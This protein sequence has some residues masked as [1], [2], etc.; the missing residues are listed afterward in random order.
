M[1]PMHTR[2]RGFIA[3]I[4]AI[5][6]SVILLGL[7]VAVGS[8]TFFARF[9]ALNRE[10]KRISLGLAES[11]VHAALAKIS[12]DYDYTI[13]GDPDYDSGRGGVVVDLD[14]VYDRDV[15]CLITG[16]LSAPAEVGGKKVFSIRTKAQYA[17]AFSSLEVS[18]TAQDPEEAPIVPPPNC[19]LQ[20]SPTSIPLGQSA[21]L[22]WSTTANADSLS[23]DHGVGGVAVSGP[24]WKSVTPAGVGT[25][26]Y[27]ATVSNEGGSNTCD[28]T[29]TVVAPP[30]A[31]SC[32][33][34][35]M[36]LDRS[37]S[38]FGYPDYPSGYTQWVP[39]E[40]AAAKTLIDLYD[41]VSS[42]PLVGW[43][44]IGDLG[45]G[46]G[47][48]LVRQ[49]SLNYADLKNSIDNGMPSNPIGYTN[50][51]EAIDVGATELES[52]RHDDDKEKVLIF[53]S[54]GVPNE[55]SGGILGDTLWRS[56]TAT[57]SPNE[58]SSPSAAFASDNARASADDDDDD[59]GYRSFDFPI[60]GNATI[61]GIEVGLEGYVVGG[62]PQNTLLWSTSFGSGGDDNDIDDWD[63][64]GND[65]D[66][67]T[68]SRQNQGSGEDTASPDGARF[69]RI[70]N[71]EWICKTVD[72]SGMTDVALRYYWRGDA[73]AEN[74]EVGV[75]EYRS[76]GSCTSSAN[77]WTTARSHELDD[78][79]NNAHEAWSSQQSVDL[80]DNFDGF[81][82]FRNAANETNEHFR[83]DGVSAT[84][85]VTPVNTS[86]QLQARIGDAGSFS[87]Y[88]SVTL[89]GTE[90]VFPALGS[91]T[92]DWDNVS[93]S[94]GDFSN[95][96]FRLETRFNDPDGNCDASATGY[97]DHVRA[98]VS[99]SVPVDPEQYALDAAGDAKGDGVKIF[100]IHFGDTA[101]L[102]LMAQLASA[103][104]LGSAPISSATRSGG[105]ATVTTSAPH[106]LTD[107]Q[108]VSIGGVSSSAFNGTF[109]VT[110]VT[111]ATTFR[112]AL[113]GSGS[114]TG[115]SITPLNLFISPSSGAMDDIFE[116]IGR[117][118]CPAAA[119]QCSNGQDDSDGD[120][121]A[122]DADPGCHTDGNAANLDS[123]DP[124]DNDEWSAP[125]I[126]PAP[127]PPPPP[128]NISIGSWVEQ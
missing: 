55:P 31:P 97:L 99:Y 74:N 103:S 21:Q 83:V 44:R 41:G 69:A 11:C 27:V 92:D 106:R 36:M 89:S 62:G 65:G 93:W 46:R 32:A 49:L 38:M 63:E 20:A 43:G 105:T 22:L 87:S 68:L 9:N 56:P 58:W 60:P 95:G 90:T 1:T 61:R 47:A 28:A 80:P 72:A 64:E 96:N 76:G 91:P 86:C 108:R 113:S 8:S 33:D 24:P 51:G 125:P 23:I 109:T 118:V 54:D 115:G 79:N 57:A 67:S 78:G 40:R 70:G 59:Q 81:V 121:L 128:P 116:S 111:N 110:G 102:S 19:V 107:N 71:S 17:N 3:L 26:T 10:Y 126:S 50:L 5:I 37:Y 122:D 82:R 12:L 52:V 85:S 123:Y 29:I 18:A 42:N 124:D 15:D 84:A 4:S 25:V 73:D 34:T 6:I 98:R 35:V 16:P 120:G 14:D 114:G 112:Y 13:T 53:V 88:R 100:S 48:D 66:S 30:P 45:D 75:V 101:G 39:N 7:A 77:S 119:P 94:V 104:S 2:N 127:P 117:Q